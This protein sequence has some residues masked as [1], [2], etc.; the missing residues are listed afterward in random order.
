MSHYAIHSPFQFGDRFAVHY[1]DS[2]LKAPTKAFAIMIEGM[3]KSL[4]HSLDQLENLGVVCIGDHSRS[5]FGRQ[6]ARFTIWRGS[7]RFECVAASGKESDAL[8]RSD[9]G[10]SYR[11]T[12]EAEF[13]MEVGK[14]VGDSE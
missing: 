5:I 4:G 12:G 10:S 3:D 14:A 2:D 9:A 1:D 11:I 6:W 7:R 8:R 13:L